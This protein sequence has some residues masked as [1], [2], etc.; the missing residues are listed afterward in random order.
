MKILLKFILSVILVTLFSCNSETGYEYMPNM[1]RSPSLE[2]YG[3]NKVTESNAL[4]P[5]KG[6]I[7]RG[8]I[9]FEYDNDLNGYLMAGN[10]L[11][12]PIELNDKNK[13]EGE[14]LYSMFCAHCHGSK[15]MGDGSIA[16]PVYSAI[17]AYNDTKVTRR[18]GGT[19]AELKAGH[20]FHTIT[21][22][23]NAMG[24][25]ASQ[26]SVDERWKIVYYVQDELQ[27]VD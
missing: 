25:H 21:Y 8:V 14:N 24:P 2:T 19:M 26:L 27:K 11:E 16:H 9:P 1:Y 23:L 3:E 13:E 20:I 6:T 5:V 7:P 4:L 17:P 18:T 10:N 12:N 22:G 15:G